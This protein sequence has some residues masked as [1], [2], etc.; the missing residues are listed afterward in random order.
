MRVLASLILI[1]ITSPLFAQEVAPLPKPRPAATAPQPEAPAAPPEAPS[2]EAETATGEPT[3][4]LPRPRPDPTKPAAET[5]VPAD[6]AAPDTPAE[7]AEQAPAETAKEEPKEPE[8]PRIYQTACPAVIAGQ[9]EA[10]MLPPIEDGICR[11]QSPLSITGVMANGRM[12]PFTGEATLDCGMATALPAWVAD[13]DGY[14]QA[15]ANTGIESIIVGTSYMCRN[16]NNASAGNVSFHGFADALD[17]VGFKLSDG[18]TLTIEQAWSGTEP[19]EQ[20]IVKFA[21]DAACTRFTTVLGPEANALHH[22]HLHLDLGCHGSRCV[23]R[24]CE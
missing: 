24:L 18:R 17:V 22:D 21:H 5:P 14:L 1:A 3:V 8:P 9:V 6:A 15:Y 16:V 4:P 12:I 7:A 20:R 11:V 19:Q 2:V 10:T 23:A 13:V